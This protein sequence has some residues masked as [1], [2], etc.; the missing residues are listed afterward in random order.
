M[1]TA[2]WQHCLVSPFP[3]PHPPKVKNAETFLVALYLKKMLQIIIIIIF[4]IPPHVREP[5]CRLIR[6][7][8]HPHFDGMTFMKVT[9]LL[10]KA[11][12]LFFVSYST[13]SVKKD[14]DVKCENIVGA[15]VLDFQSGHHLTCHNV[16]KH[17][18]HTSCNVIY[19]STDSE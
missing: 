13:S 16:S 7:L 3:P 15:H 9:T 8:P 11:E 14:K 10:L 2:H 19:F 17:T 5:V 12:I 6:R 18:K 1:T 4:L